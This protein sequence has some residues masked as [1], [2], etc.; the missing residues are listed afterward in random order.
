MLG[1][2]IDVFSMMSMRTHLLCSLMAAYSLYL[3]AKA[4]KNSSVPGEIRN[5][6]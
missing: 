6:I 1:V 3:P 5:K 4:G 2:R